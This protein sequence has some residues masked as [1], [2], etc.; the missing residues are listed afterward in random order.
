M[1][2]KMRFTFPPSPKIEI[3]KEHKFEKLEILKSQGNSFP[4][5]I[6]R[7]ISRKQFHWIM[8]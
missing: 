8:E 2:L 3:K 6:T 7:N 1:F 5:Y 4:Q